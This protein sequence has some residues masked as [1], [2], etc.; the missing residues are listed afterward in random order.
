MLTFGI[1]RAPRAIESSSTTNSAH[2][3]LL[4]VG[5]KGVR[6]GGNRQRTVS[7]HGTIGRAALVFTR[8]PVLESCSMPDLCR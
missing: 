1:W 2:V 3:A 6:S 4:S 8:H 5:H 7:I